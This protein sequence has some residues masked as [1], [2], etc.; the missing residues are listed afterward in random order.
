ML[1]KNHFFIIF[2]TILQDS[3][4]NS[5][6]IIY[7]DEYINEVS[8]DGIKS[9]WVEIVLPQ[10]LWS[11]PNAEFGWVFGG[12]LKD[13]VIHEEDFSLARQSDNSR[14]YH[15]DSTVYFIVYSEYDSLFHRMIHDDVLTFKPCGEFPYIQIE[16]GSCH[17]YDIIQIG[18]NFN[19]YEK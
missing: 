2:F 5:N 10:Y 18:P 11:G 13:M 3:M 17:N 12:Y 15:D 7:T 19:R 14:F 6:S 8:I 9:A 1:K 4:P 16:K